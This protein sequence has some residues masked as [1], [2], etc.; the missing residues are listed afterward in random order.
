MLASQQEPLLTDPKKKYKIYG[1]VEPGFERVLESYIAL[2]EQGV[3][4]NSQLC[5]YHK[6]RKVVDVWGE[7]P[8]YRKNCKFNG[9]SLMDIFSSGKSLGNICI[10]ILHD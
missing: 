8:G 4:K 7:W 10:N 5:I 2:F 9:D 1:T 3:E 6:E